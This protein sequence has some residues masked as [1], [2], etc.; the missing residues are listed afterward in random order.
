MTRA[1]RAALIAAVA[2]LAFVG[3]L[4]LGPTPWRTGPT[5]ADY[6]VLSLGTWLDPE[7]WAGGMAREFAANVV[8]FI[9]LG[10][11]LRWAFPR[12]TWAGAALLGGVVSF[13]IE[14]GQMWGPRVSDP[15]DI[16][17]N[18]GGALLGAVIAA[19]LS[20]MLRARRSRRPVLETAG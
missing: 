7:T 13:G 15:R 5:E 1:S 19:V 10:M 4:T 2:Y 18:T 9:P 16:L 14:V 11:L 17:A 8:L 6:D 12:L 20:R 3:I